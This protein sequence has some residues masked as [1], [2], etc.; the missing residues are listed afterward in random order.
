[1]GPSG[2]FPVTIH[3]ST[4]RT[5]QLK[6]SLSHHPQN[7]ESEFVIQ[8][9]QE[10][11][12]ELLAWILGAEEKLTQE[13]RQRG[14]EE[15][16][17][18]IQEI[19][20]S[21]DDF[22]TESRVKEKE[23]QDALQ[24]GVMLVKSVLSKPEDLREIEIQREL[25][26]VK[27]EELKNL[28]MDKQ[29]R[30]HNTLMA[31]QK[32]QLKLFSD[33]LKTAEAQ[34]ASFAEI[35]TDLQAV[36]EQ[37][38][39][40]MAFQNE[41]REHE[42][43]VN[44]LLN[45]VIII[46][47]CENPNYSSE[48]L[49]DDL[50]DQIEALGE[51]WKN[52][53]RIVEEREATLNIWITLLKNEAEFTNWVAK[54]ENRLQGIQNAVN[55][56]LKSSGSG[57]SYLGELLGR[58][59]R[60]EDDE[61]AK[62]R[63]YFSIFQVLQKQLKTINQSSLAAIR[64]KE[65]IDSLSKQC[66]S[67]TAL[68]KLLSV[69]IQ[70]MYDL[71][72][73]SKLER[74]GSMRASSLGHPSNKQLSTYKIDDWKKSVGEFMKSLLEHEETLGVRQNGGQPAGGQPAGDL[75]LD[76][77]DL[78][79]QEELID[80]LQFE[81]G[82]K[83]LE[84]QG[85]VQQGNFLIGELQKLNRATDELEELI[86]SMKPRWGQLKDALEDRQQKLDTHQRLVRLH[87]ECNSLNR[88][89]NQT[90]NRLEN[91]KIIVKKLNSK[92]NYREINQVYEQ[93]KLHKNPMQSQN[94]RVQAIEE[95]YQECVRQF[96]KLST[97]Q[98]ALDVQHFLTCWQ[99]MNRK[100]DEF[101]TEVE[102]MLKLG[103]LAKKKEEKLSEA[104]PKL[105]TAIDLLERW[106]IKT[107][108][109][110]FVGQLN[111]FW[112]ADEYEEQLRSFRGLEK[113]IQNEK[114]NLDYINETGNKVVQMHA[115]AA[116]TPSFRSKVRD[117]NRRWTE[118]IDILTNKIRHLERLRDLVPK[119]D[120]QIGEFEA[121]SETAQKFLAGSIEFGDFEMMDKQIEQYDALVADIDDEVLK[122]IGLINDHYKAIKEII[123][124]SDIQ[125]LASSLSLNEL[126]RADE[127]QQAANQTFKEE[128]KEKVKEQ[129]DSWNV[130]RDEAVS[131]R[132]LLKES[133]RECQKINEKVDEFDQEIEK[134]KCDRLMLSDIDSLKSHCSNL[135]TINE[136]LKKKL[137]SC[138][139][140]KDNLEKL[141]KKGKFET[142][143]CLEKM[144]DK[145]TATER[146][147]GD[148]IEEITTICSNGRTI[149]TKYD[150]L[151]KMYTARAHWLDKLEAIISRS[152][153]EL[154][155]SEEISDYIDNL[156]NHLKNR[157][158][159]V[160]LDRVEQIINDLN[161]LFFDATG[162]VDQ[163]EE[164][165]LS[166]TAE[167]GNRDKQL[168]QMLGETQELEQQLM[169]MQ[170]K[171]KHIETNLG[172]HDEPLDVEHFE[173]KFKDANQM[174]SFL[175]EQIDK[176]L[177]EQRH[178]A[179]KRFKEQLR[180]LQ[181]SYSELDRRFNEMK[182]SASEMPDVNLEKDT[183]I[184]D[185]KKVYDDL[186]SRQLTSLETQLIQQKLF[187]VTQPLPE[188]QNRIQ[189]LQRSAHSLDHQQFSGPLEASEDQTK[190]SSKTS[191]PKS[192][193]DL[194]LTEE[195]S[196][197]SPSANLSGINGDCPPNSYSPNGYYDGERTPQAIEINLDNSEYLNEE[198]LFED[199]VDEPWE[200]CVT[201]NYVPYYKN[202][203]R[204]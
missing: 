84:Y 54:T 32:R 149:Q 62:R 143:I 131:K 158:A 75:P 66:Q 179:A 195:L 110:V 20:Q 191:I 11:V 70:A 73:Q 169:I 134:I 96:A 108:Q 122:R 10:R 163:Q 79:K 178:I 119:L 4:N 116:W 165:W 162:Y 55:D 47:E 61:N 174:I 86:E 44:T 152:T 180:F 203:D 38:K 105:V 22:T 26:A 176:L 57:T 126:P 106:L 68:R 30:L 157:P 14:R 187:E 98:R 133:L 42:L 74:K 184:D 19:F 1:M 6:H 194:E 130:I 48:N 114:G 36:I 80:E 58:L 196:K 65:K 9:Y 60:M 125:R 115:D 141:N 168:I 111:L 25:L 129:I 200:R 53:C 7:V 52:V 33:W 136:R 154:V 88:F 167:A 201:N 107:Y 172:D 135:E 138:F 76:D 140:M 94:K 69:K 151:C 190:Q 117:L 59:K 156:E 155:D 56:A 8:R 51:K 181:I 124:S 3:R 85:L 23:I 104:Y 146:K 63:E 18:T 45:M 2:I 95:E 72:T 82:E 202:H 83:E 177:A 121:W 21:L 123:K 15:S 137:N 120:K 81:F 71:Q 28:I 188:L 161:E 31:L 29:E 204:E 142:K 173:A 109:I 139:K 43:H 67:I 145:I 193:S 46:D 118:T 34:I 185:L 112:G 103:K 40:H 148:L 192:Q 91:E 93:W 113:D 199:S 183:L 182:S 171:L 147:C 166:S 90:N 189:E 132:D 150:E 102:A 99:E 77:A 100:I 164:R 89:L 37:L 153:Q 16:M 49:T 159:D 64:I 101:K 160:C 198:E 197:S 39:A 5:I 50:H 35:E 175:E 92:Q 41:V 13:Q 170:D 27:W 97:D 24:E 87:G 127:E 186:A 128:L 78:N 12:E 144:I 17:D